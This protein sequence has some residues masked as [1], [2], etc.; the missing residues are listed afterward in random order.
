MKVIRLKKT[1]PPPDPEQ[2]ALLAGCRYGDDR[3]PGI[4]RV[5][6]GKGF[7]FVDPKGHRVTDKKTLSRIFALV[8][9]P[10]WTDVW[11]S[12]DPDGHLQATGRDARGRKQYRYHARFR[13]IREETK[14]E[15][16]LAFAE[17]LPRIRGVVD[18]HMSAKSLSRQNVLATIV[19]LLETSLIRVGNEEYA[20]ENGSF[21]LTTMRTR[22]VDIEGST[23]HFHFRGK[24]GKEH[25]IDVR[26]RRIARV[27]QRCNDLPGEE[28]FQYVDDEGTRRTIESSDVNEYLK[29]IS[30]DAFT[31]KDFRTWAGTVLTAE[32]L[33]APFE[34][35][36]QAKRNV[37][38][39]IKGVAQRLG[40]TATVCRKCYVH[41][42]IVS[43]YFDGGLSAA[44]RLRDVEKGPSQGATLSRLEAAV[45]SHLRTAAV[46]KTT[47]AAEKEAAKSSARKAATS[48]KAA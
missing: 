41:P 11:I 16:M 45:L 40:N 23:L 5:K 2:S 36:T 48:K 17:S 7:T 6:K 39:A 26:D 18:E 32:A 35:V 13:E 33:V 34:N 38:E 10:A 28:L 21:G 20:R 8:L 9:P 12:L 31:A 29:T 46:K 3:L 27:V 4:R 15:R 30:G 22:H 25:V 37:R 44:V 42:V 24:S 43:S 47:S 1:A 14:F 19:R